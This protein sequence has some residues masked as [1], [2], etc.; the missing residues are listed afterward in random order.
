MPIFITASTASAED[1]DAPI[2]EK[3]YIH[4]KTKN[5]MNGS[6]PDDGSDLL[7]G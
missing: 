1:A 2:V 7:Q 4:Q 6:A 3:G 5:I